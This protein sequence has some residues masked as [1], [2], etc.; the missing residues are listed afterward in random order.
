MSSTLP[1]LQKRYGS[2]TLT[3]AC[4]LALL[5]GAAVF[6]PSVRGQGVLAPAPST[7]LRL[8]I[9]EKARALQ[10]LQARREAVEKNLEEIR[11]SG[12]SLKS[13]LNQI[14]ATVNQLG[15]SIRTNEITLEKLGLEYEE[16]GGGIVDAQRSI[17]NTKET[18]AKLFTE[19]QRYERQSIISV[20]FRNV[21]LSESVSEVQS[22]VTLQGQLIGNIAKLRE[23]QCTLAEKR[24]AAETNRARREVEITDLAS[25]QRIVQDQKQEKQVLLTVT[26]SQE[27]IYQQQL[28]DLKQLQAAVSQEI[29]GIESQLRNTIDPNLLPLARPGVLLWPVNGG[30]LTQCYGRTPFAIKNYGSQYH[31]G[32]DIGAPVGTEVFSAADGIVINTGNQ[33][34]YRGC[35]RAGYGK[36]IEIKHTNGL[37]TLYGH[38]S[39]VIATVG[40]E[41]AKGEVIGYVGRT[42]WATGPHL[43]FTVFA[44]QTLTPARGNLPEGAI[45]SRSCGPMPV[46][47]DINPKLYVDSLYIDLQKECKKY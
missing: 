31:N 28:D 27:Q 12:D 38:L 23:L 7:V 1:F 10:E 20:I 5:A 37:T 32:I 39:E 13:E 42:G 26:K 24:T 45:S 22:I 44:S 34:K 36:F 11:G 40:Q 35:Y 19:L 3:F 18:I 16:L 33:D 30:H 25:R 15:L 9:E 47:G 2:A 29:E 6:V 8:Q 46:G 43:H 4:A 17:V 14:D 41:V 21:S